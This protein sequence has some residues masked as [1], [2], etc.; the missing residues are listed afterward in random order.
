MAPYSEAEKER[1][2]KRNKSFL[3]S[4]ECEEYNIDVEIGKTSK[5][6]KTLFYIVFEILLR[7]ILVFFKF[8]TA[9]M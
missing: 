4:G 9:K 1:R 5:C 3:T 2:P 7:I 8:K 6:K